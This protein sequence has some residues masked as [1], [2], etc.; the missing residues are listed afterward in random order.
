[1]IKYSFKQGLL[2]GIKYLLIFLIPVLVDKFIIAYP[3]IAQLT[4]GG[5]LVMLVNFIKIKAFK[6]GEINS[7]T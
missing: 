3:E 7:T 6:G 2:K 5:I 4:V 1:M